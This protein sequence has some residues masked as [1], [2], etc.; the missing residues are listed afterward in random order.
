MSHPKEPY[1]MDPA[2]ERAV[3]TLCASRANFWGR[4]GFALDPACMGLPEATL[5]LETIRVMAK[6]RS[7]GPESAL[8]VL[9]RLRR[10]MSEGKVTLE[11]I[12]Q[13]GALFDAAEDAGLPNEE[14]VVAELVPVLRRRLESEA[15]LDAHDAYA[16]RKSLD[17]V[18]AKIEASRRLGVT[19]TSVGMDLQ[20]G[21]STIEELEGVERL[22]TGILELD[23]QLDQGMPR[24]QLGFVLGDSGAGKSMWLVAQ[25]CEAIRSQHNT[26]YATLELPKHVQLARLYANLTGVPFK[27][28]LENPLDR[29]EAQRRME[30][31]HPSV[32]SMLV[33]E[34]PPYATTVQ[35]IVEWTARCEDYLGEPVGC[36]VI[37]YADKMHD[38]KVRQDDDY[39]AMRNVYEGLRVRVAHQPG[40]W[41]WTASQATRP[42]NDREKRLG[43]HHASDSHH[44]GRVSD[45]VLTL[46]V[47]DDGLQ[48]LIFCAKNRTGRANFQVGPLPTDFDRARIVPAPSEWTDWSVQVAQEQK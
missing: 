17:G 16:N 39:H 15:I 11:Q 5:I 21:F 32:G 8:L 35:D 24:G 40:R 37:D 43:L 18:T 36:V 9:Q 12:K 22:Q 27:C 26:I 41:A 20:S 2:F 10:K 25:A 19:N 47:R 3:L 28:I 4:L 14:S 45:V 34:F 48:M 42:A 6:E 29:K 31:M 1:W 44:K 7:H 23:L 33:E 30:I 46:N 38:P 13:V